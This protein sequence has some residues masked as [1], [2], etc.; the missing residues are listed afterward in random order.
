VSR[1]ERHSAVV[2]LPY[3]YDR[4]YGGWWEPVLRRDAKLVVARSA[5]RYVQLLRR[6]GREFR[7]R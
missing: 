3:R 5:E 4:I 2:G 1:C 7:Q 6:E